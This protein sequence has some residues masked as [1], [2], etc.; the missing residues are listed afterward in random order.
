VAVAPLTDA[1]SLFQTLLPSEHFDGL[2]HRG[3][4][5][6]NNR[7]YNAAVVMWLTISQRMR[8]GTMATSV[9]ELIRGLPSSFW[10]LPCKRLQAGPD[11]RR[12]KLSENP[13]SYHDALQT[14]PV[15]V[16]ELSFDQAF[17]GMMT[18]AKGKLPEVGEVF[19]VDGTSARTA[20]SPSLCEVYPVGKNAGRKTHW[21]V[22]R[23]LVAHDACTGLAMRPHWGPMY[24]PEAVSEQGLLVNV[25]DRLPGGATLLGDINFG[26]FWVAYT[27]DQKGHPLVLR[28]QSV[29]AQRLLGG[30]L[31]DGMDR[32]IEWR[33]SS[34]ERKS[35]QLPAD[36]CVVGRVIVRQVQ[37][38]NGDQPLLL[39]LFTTLAGPPE[40]IVPIYG[41]RWNIETDLR[42]L[43]SDLRLEQL[44]FTSPEMVAKELILGMLAY[45]LIRAVTYLAAQATGL[46]PRAF[47]FTQVRNVINAFG[48]LIAAA[49]DPQEAQRQ[50]ENMMYYASRARLPKRRQPRSSSPRV[51]WGKPRTFPKPKE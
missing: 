45:N 23:V 49:R 20:H 38:S 32:R 34:Q 43:K 48:P 21:P 9:L 47:S 22:L 16:V 13:T 28:L 4:L 27:A 15:R 19:F 42:S 6:E 51:A 24:G 29:R 36:A 35:H 2:R 11:G 5:R 46:A 39:A 41:K 1:L 25:L 50:F 18:E 26:V 10:P 44:T 31:Q 17:A 37:P 12:K 14:L 8:A 40:E 3:T 33:P 30:P 7:V